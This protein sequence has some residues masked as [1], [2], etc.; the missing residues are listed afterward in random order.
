MLCTCDYSST[1]SLHQWPQDYWH[2]VD[3]LKGSGLDVQLKLNISP[4]GFVSF[5]VRVLNGCK[6][7]DVTAWPLHITLGYVGEIDWKTVKSL[8]RTW[9][10]QVIHLPI[11]WVGKGGTAMI[12]KCALTECSLVRRAHDLGRY[13]YVDKLHVSF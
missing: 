7:R 2:R 5:H 12:S 11:D 8:R 4:D 10:N 1:C 6:L 13:W 3:K 9:H